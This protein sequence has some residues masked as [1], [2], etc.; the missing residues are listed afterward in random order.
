MAPTKILVLGSGLVAKPCVDYLHR[1]TENHLTVACRTLAA[2]EKL[3]AGFPRATAIALDVQSPDLDRQVA[4]HD[5]VI[6]LVPF[7]YHADII[8]S[9]IKGKTNVVTTS[10]VSAAMHELDGPAKEAGITVL[11]EVGVDPG[12]D[13]L[14]AVK[15]ISEIH[16]KGGKVKEFHSYCGGLPAPEAADNPLR[17]KVFRHLVC[18]P[19]ASS[20]G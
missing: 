5:V 1:N 4:D 7:I 17:F 14:Y 18:V 13:H 15:T 12:V 10:Y 16:D 19:H 8:C 6:S 2:A 3:A 20:P 11:N 9:A